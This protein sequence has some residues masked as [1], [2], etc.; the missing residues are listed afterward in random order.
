MPVNLP[1]PP[2]RVKSFSVP[3]KR[4]RKNPQS[5]RRILYDIIAID[6]LGSCTDAAKEL[7]DCLTGAEQF[8]KHRTLFTGESLYRVARDEQPISFNQ[9]DA[10]SLYYKVPMSLILL[11]SRLRSEIEDS[12]GHSNKSALEVIECMKSALAIIERI[13]RDA[14]SDLKNA[15]DYMNH[16]RFLE[17]VAAYKSPPEQPSLFGSHPPEAR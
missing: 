8:R 10:M 1:A 3:N 15:Y 13:V 4:E 6:F 16:S 12:T 9:L 11:F 7:S 14:P 5:L 2:R 17:M